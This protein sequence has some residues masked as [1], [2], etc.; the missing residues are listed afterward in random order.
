MIHY[1]DF[2]VYP[3]KLTFGF[4]ASFVALF[5]PVFMPFSFWKI[6]NLQI[7][8]SRLKMEVLPDLVEGLEMTLSRKNEH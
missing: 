8:M 5:W 6:K 1:A 2:S 7:A 3:W 4:L